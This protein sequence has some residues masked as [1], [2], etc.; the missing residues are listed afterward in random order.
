MQAS[1][2][3]SPPRMIRGVDFCSLGASERVEYAPVIFIHATRVSPIKEQPGDHARND[4][5]K[6]RV[7]VEEDSAASRADGASPSDEHDELRQLG[8][9]IADLAASINGARKGT[10]GE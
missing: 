9:R 8:E 2:P 1:G 4:L 6:R 3:H 7:T 10:V 5:R